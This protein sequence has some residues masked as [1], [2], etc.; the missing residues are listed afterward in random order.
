MSIDERKIVDFVGIR[1]SDG[2]CTLTISDHLAWDDP[3]HVAQL[4]D[5]LNDYLAFIESGEI[6]QKFP[7]V[8]GRE[9]EI[10]IICMHMP[11]ADDALSFLEYAARKIRGAGIHFAVRELKQMER[12]VV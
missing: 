12:D 4:E 8:S 3:D 1:A 10:Q 5:K 9:I 11:P 7:E 6:Y 2:R